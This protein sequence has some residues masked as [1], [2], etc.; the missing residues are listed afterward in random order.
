MMYFFMS[1]KKLRK[2]CKNIV[3]DQ[4]SDSWG[5]DGRANCNI[6]NKKNLD[7]PQSSSIVV[8]FYFPH[9]RYLWND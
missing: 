8:L 7:Y 5:T 2:S 6:F 9:L 3:N 4:S 1:G